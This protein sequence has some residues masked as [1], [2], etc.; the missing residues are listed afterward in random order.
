M[1]DPR[2]AI[3][4]LIAVFVLFM[5]AHQGWSPTATNF[6]HTYE[7]GTPPGKLVSDRGSFDFVAM[8]LLA[9]IWWVPISAA[10][11]TTFFGRK[12]YEALHLTITFVTLLFVLA[13]IGN[14]VYNYLG[15]NPEP[16]TIGA[17]IDYNNPATDR[18]WCCVHGGTVGAPCHITAGCVPIVTHEML[19]ID[20]TFAI[21]SIMNCVLA[22]LLIFDFFWVCCNY[23]QVTERMRL[24]KAPPKEEQVYK[25]PPPEE[26]DPGDE[27]GLRFMGRRYIYRK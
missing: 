12:S 5:T 16:G 18:R 14:G 23:I 10:L 11:M 9:F 21:S 15:A 3:W 4:I 17:S 8:F 1:A 25:S 26:S 13:T 24:Y 2:V 20:V 6:K 27:V 7:L 19:G 22:F